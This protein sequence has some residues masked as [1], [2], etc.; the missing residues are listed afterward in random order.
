[1][2]PVASFVLIL[3][4]IFPVLAVQITQPVT[5]VY[6]FAENLTPPPM[7]ETLPPYHP[8]YNELDEIMGDTVIIGNTGWEGQHNGTVG[9]AIGQ[10][11]GEGDDAA[12]IHLVWTD[13][14][15]DAGERHVKYNR[16][17]IGEEGELVVE[18]EDGYQ[19]DAGV[20]AGYTTLGMS[21]LENKAFTAYHMTEDALDPYESWITVED[22]FFPGTFAEF[23]LPTFDTNENIW[24]RSRIL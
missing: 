4:M 14:F 21:S 13:L 9:R 17:S 10:W 8:S 20:R 3:A 16:V 19:V 15:E 12:V 5:T 24:P 6:E 11:T 18:V 23:A 22:I 1:M 2:R 7:P